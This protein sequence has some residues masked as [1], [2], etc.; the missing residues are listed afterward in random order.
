MHA[1]H[2]VKVGY[3]FVQDDHRAIHEQSKYSESKP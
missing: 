3:L 2:T 1:R